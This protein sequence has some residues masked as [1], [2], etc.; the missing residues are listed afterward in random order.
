[1][2]IIQSDSWERKEKSRNRQHQFRL[3]AGA[4]AG[5]V[6]PDVVGSTAAGRVAGTVVD[7]PVGGTGPF[8]PGTESTILSMIS[9]AVSG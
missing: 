6:A 4:E 2:S 8:A 5:F 1:M 9:D 7:A 3:P